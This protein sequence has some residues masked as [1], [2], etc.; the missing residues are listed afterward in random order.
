MTEATRRSSAWVGP[1]AVRGA[2]ASRMFVG[3]PTVAA[4]ASTALS[5]HRSGGVS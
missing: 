3:G 1:A 4:R 5:V 2:D